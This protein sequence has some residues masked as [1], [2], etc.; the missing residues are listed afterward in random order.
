MQPVNPAISIRGDANVV[1]SGL[2][3][4]KSAA[5]L[6]A[7]SFS[8]F[9]ALALL[10]AA[11]GA[12]A[13]ETDRFAGEAGFQFLKL[14][15]SPRITALGGAGAA[16]ADGVG[17]M[18][19]NPAAGATGGGR[20]VLGYGQPYAEFG[21]SGSHLHVGAPWGRERVL[22]G[23]RYLGFDDIAGYD[24]TDQATA[25]YGAHT[26]KFQAGLAGNRWGFDYGATLGFAQNHIAEAT[27]S[28]GL[29]SLGLRRAL[30]WGFSAGASLV[31][32]DFWSH[33]S[34]GGGDIFPPTAA[35]AGLAHTQ[36]WPREFR[37]VL[38]ADLRTR[39]DEET[40]ALLG[41]E[42]VWREMLSLRLGY[43]VGEADAA[44]SAGVGVFFQRFRV[45]YAY[46]G[47]AALSAAH[48]GSLEIAY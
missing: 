10:L 5:R 4:R 34:T 42:G 43:P 9:C 48:Y 41:F 31:N 19:L 12:Q 1:L 14:P 7:A 23:L 8:G 20:L 25:D 35:Q 45:Q 28:L 46:Q 15:L 36:V 22:I 30:P 17:E 33:S 24:A 21:A 39:N 16:I 38:A 26:Y 47:H 44:L 3:A 13:L 40:E 11:P 18:D 32:A 27:Y 29:A 37:T 2:F 6:P